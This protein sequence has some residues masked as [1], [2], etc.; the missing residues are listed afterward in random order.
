MTIGDDLNSIK[1][2]IWRAIAQSGVDISSIPAEQQ[3]ILVSRIAEGVILNLDG[4]LQEENPYPKEIKEDLA[5]QE[6]VLW[7]GRPFLS[8]VE[9]YMVTTERIK[10][11]KGLFGRDVEIFELI[12]LQDI[13]YKQN[14]G[15]RIIN[16]GDIFI[17]GQDPSQPELVLRNIVDPEK[18]Y[19]TL[20]KAWLSARKRHGLQFREFM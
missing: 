7:E 4:I 2:S 1:S 11:V 15:E 6:K 8:I 13:D 18:V 16:R 14:M 10:I 19:E 9:T 3:E 5:D 20:R 17:R 12:R